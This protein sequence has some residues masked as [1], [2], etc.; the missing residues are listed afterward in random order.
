[1]EGICIP[2]ASCSA[3]SQAGGENL[4][5]NNNL[6]NIPL[7]LA[8]QTDRLIEIALRQLDSRNDP[9]QS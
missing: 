9:V 1:M 4:T 6:L 5:L 7:Y 8:D 2:H 3:G